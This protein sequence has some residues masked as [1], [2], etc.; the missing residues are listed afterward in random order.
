MGLFGLLDIQANV[1]S[2]VGSSKS[3]IDGVKRLFKE[4]RVWIQLQIMY[5]I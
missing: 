5:K 3:T 2:A 1:S 4:L